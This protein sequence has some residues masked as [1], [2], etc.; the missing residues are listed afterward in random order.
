M[1]TRR[2]SGGGGGGRQ[3]TKTQN[4]GGEI[5]AKNEKEGPGAETGNLGVAGWGATPTPGGGEGALEKVKRDNPEKVQYMGGGGRPFHKT[6]SGG[7][8]GAPT[9]RGK[10]RDSTKKKQGPGGR[11]LF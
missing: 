7:G 10:L 4:R 5:K 8:K 1:E 6:I 2:G 9:K 11:R 3:Q